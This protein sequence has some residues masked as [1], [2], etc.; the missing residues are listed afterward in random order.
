M[1]KMKLIIAIFLTLFYVN[2]NCQQF[3]IKGTS[4]K[5]NALTYRLTRDPNDQAGMI[6]LI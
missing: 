3:L 5:L 6:H 2:A 1:K 4:Q